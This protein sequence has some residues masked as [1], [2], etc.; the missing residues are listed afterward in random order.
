MYIACLQGK[1]RVPA[2]PHVGNIGLASDYPVPVTS[3]VPS[4][5][6]VCTT[7]LLL[8]LLLLLPLLLPPAISCQELHAV[9]AVRFSQV[10]FSL[11]AGQHGPQAHRP[12]QQVLPA[13]RGAMPPA[14]ALH[15]RLDL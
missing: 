9:S 12:R 6:G 3:T 5:F 15:T 1:W 13:C 11:G 14:C 8:L 10:L 2:N 7:Y 4:K